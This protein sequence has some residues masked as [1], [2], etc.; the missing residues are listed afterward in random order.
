MKRSF[1]INMVMWAALP[2]VSHAQV[3]DAQTTSILNSYSV[4][5]AIFIGLAASLWVFFDA[6]KMDGGVFGNALMYFSI[7]MF[8]LLV[9]FIAGVLAS[10]Y[11]TFMVYEKLAHDVLYIIGY[12]FMALGAHRIYQT[13][14]K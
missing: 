4:V 3:V 2:V 11:P 12:I 6:R 5:S 14:K 10:F 1:I 7:G 13:I 9:G 8:C